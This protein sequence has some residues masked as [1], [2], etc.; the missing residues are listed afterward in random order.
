I[1]TVPRPAITRPSTLTSMRPSRRASTSLAATSHGAPAGA[2]PNSVGPPCGVGVLPISFER[3]TRS[4]WPSSARAEPTRLTA[5]TIA[6]SRT[7]TPTLR[8][9]GTPSS[10]TGHPYRRP[11]A[12]QP[13]RGLLGADDRDR[14]AG[15][16]RLALLD[17]E[18]GDDAGLV[19]GDLVLHLHRLD[20]ADE[21]AFLDR[22][23]RLD[24]DLPH[25]AL[26]RS[27]ERIAA[28]RP[29]AAA[30]APAA[31]AL[32]ALRRAARPWGKG[33][34]RPVDAAGRRWPDHLH[35]E[36]AARDLDGVVALDRLARVLAVG[37]LR[38]RRERERLE[39]RAVLDQ[40]AAGLAA[41]PLL[42]GEQRAVER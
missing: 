2:T 27:D 37:R 7:T 30:R 42:G 41:C 34:A 12:E 11:A 23:A 25:V 21:L 17:G 35:V 19:G 26:E 18:L 33:R 40:V 36:A 29:A 13:S 1:P 6:A 31:R 38:R 16:D 28:G 14:R 24:E 9:M 20:D 5:A 10:R 3:R 32:G 4:P 15:G 22:L 39:P 8:L